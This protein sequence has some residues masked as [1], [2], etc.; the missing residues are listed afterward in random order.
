[1]PLA[2]LV[3]DVRMEPVDGPAL[4]RLL[5]QASPSTRV[6]FVSGYPTDPDH[7]VVSRPILKKP[8]LPAQ[9]VEAVARILATQ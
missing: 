5:A 2:L 3:S 8:F 6:L 1:M 4:A 9:L 7:P